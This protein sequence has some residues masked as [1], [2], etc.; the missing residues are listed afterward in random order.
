MELAA[1]RRRCRSIVCLRNVVM[2]AAWLPERNSYLPAPGGGHLPARLL[3]RPLLAGNCINPW[4]VAQFGKP[5]GSAEGLYT[6]AREN[7]SA[8]KITKRAC[9]RVREADCR[10]WSAARV[11]ARTK[12][13]RP[14]SLGGWGAGWGQGIEPAG[15][16]DLTASFRGR[17]CKFSIIPA[18]PVAARVPG[19]KKAPAPASARAKEQCCPHMGPR[20]TTRST[21]AGAIPP[22]KG[23][24]SPAFRMSG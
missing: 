3:V 7:L 17:F 13:Q 5:M 9:A 11:E 21:I 20:E 16:I 1:A 19:P 15:A 12:L 6:H 23:G 14:I 8:E 18:T 2:P 22:N 10:R 24:S 4:A